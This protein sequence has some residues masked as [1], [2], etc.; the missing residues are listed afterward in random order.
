MIGSGR[1]LIVVGIMECVP[2][3]MSEHVNVWVWVSVCMSVCEHAW[4]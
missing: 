1:S 3:C 2:V 4:L